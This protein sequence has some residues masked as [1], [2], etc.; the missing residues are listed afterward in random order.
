[1]TKV[2][3]SVVNYIE[4]NI[5]LMADEEACTTSQHLAAAKLGF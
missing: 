5:V 2:V 1:M 3:V 4:V